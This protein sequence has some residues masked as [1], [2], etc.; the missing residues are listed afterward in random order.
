M[1]LLE[2]SRAD[3]ARIAGSCAGAVLG[4][5]WAL[6]VADVATVCPP[7]GEGRA[8]CVLN[9]VYLSIG[10]HVLLAGL[11]GGLVARS[12]TAAPAAWRAWRRGELLPASSPPPGAG[13]G[14]LLA[15]TWCPTPAP[16]REGRFTRPAPLPVDDAGHLRG[17]ELRAWLRAWP[18]RAGR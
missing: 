4:L 17:D 18:T 2:L 1:S 14:L 16:E 9:E 7:S 11:A 12:L 5:W 15:A 6:P 10:L 13:D 8:Q 3:V